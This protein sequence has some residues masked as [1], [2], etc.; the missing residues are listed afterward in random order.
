MKF[1]ATGCALDCSR[2]DDRFWVFPSPRL[3]G[4]FSNCLGEGRA[5]DNLRQVINEVLRGKPG[6]VPV[7]GIVAVGAW[8]GLQSDNEAHGG[9]VLWGGRTFQQTPRY[10][11]QDQE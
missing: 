2:R 7:V 4:L 6:V 9:R 8:F 1:P 10:H 3:Q 11:Y 5:L